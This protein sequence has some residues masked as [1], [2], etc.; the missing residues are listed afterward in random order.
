MPAPNCPRCNSNLQVA[1]IFYGYQTQSQAEKIVRE[2]GL[3]GGRASTDDSPRWYCKKC[4]RGFGGKYSA[5][6]AKTDR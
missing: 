1:E 6:S 3:L 2:G 5:Y 4:E